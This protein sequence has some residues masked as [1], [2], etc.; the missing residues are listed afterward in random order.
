LN[1]QEIRAKALELAIQTIALFPEEK[2]V[3]QLAM[4]KNPL[5]VLIGLSL[6]YQDYLKEKPS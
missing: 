5:E 4:D 3:E 6:P 2:R 1:E